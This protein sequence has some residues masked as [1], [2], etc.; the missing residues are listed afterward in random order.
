MIGIDRYSYGIGRSDDFVPNRV[1]QQRFLEVFFRRSIS[2]ASDPNN[3]NQPGD[4][5]RFPEPAYILS[6]IQELEPTV[7]RDFPQLLGL[8]SEARSKASAMLN[9]DTREK[10]S[11]REKRNDAN[12]SPFEQ[13]LDELEKADSEG[14]LTDG[15]I[16]SVELK[17]KREIQYKQFLPWLDKVKDEKLRDDMTSHF[18]VMRT[19]LSI[20]ESRLPDAQEFV[21][22][23]PEIE[24]RSVL[25]FRIAEKQIGSSD[26]LS[27]AR[28]LLDVGDLANKSENSVARARVLLGLSALFEKFDHL[29]ALNRLNDAIA[30]INKLEKGDM[31]QN[32]VA[33]EIH[34]PD[35]VYYVMYTSPTFGLENTFDQLSKNDFSNTYSNAAA[36]DNKYYK[37]LAIFAVAKN[38]IDK[39]PPA[40][41]AST[42][43]KN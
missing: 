39:L 23:V 24:Y 21:R 4:E 30:A 41:K 40:K 32:I 9:N 26:S 37:A 43:K 42:V 28:L 10:M 17:L 25:S 16:F 38:C 15:M 19:S 13:R 31:M 2:F 22:K 1:L 35:L 29:S 34:A 12:S 3:L 5:N 8:M 20:D 7:I 27:A 33:R 11:E 36:L 18:W 14:R 6:A